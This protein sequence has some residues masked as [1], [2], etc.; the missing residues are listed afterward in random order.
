M[1][2][3]VHDITNEKILLREDNKISLEFIIPATLKKI[4]GCRNNEFP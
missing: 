2:Q 3:N 4:A 1:A